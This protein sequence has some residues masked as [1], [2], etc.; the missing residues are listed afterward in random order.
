MWL[1]RSQPPT[2]LTTPSSLRP[3]GSWR[4]T[5]SIEPLGEYKSMYEFWLDLG[6]RMG[7]GDDF[8][9][10]SM[11]ECMN[12]QLAPLGMTIDELR[13]HPTGIVYPMKPMVY[14]KY[15]KSSPP[16]APAFE[17]AISAAG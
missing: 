4:G 15:E 13:T 2:R 12:D 17:T 7:Y 11:E 14:E 5:R 8:W 9:N 10:G 3:T 16:G 6:V 1:F